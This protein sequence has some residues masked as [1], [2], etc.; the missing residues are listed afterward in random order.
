MSILSNSHKS[1]NKVSAEDEPVVNL[2]P[3][4]NCQRHTSGTSFGYYWQDCTKNWSDK[5]HGLF[6]GVIKDTC[7]NFIQR[8]T[9]D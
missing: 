8:K 1:K 6:Y 2:R 9:N 5:T 7:D 3:C 4:L